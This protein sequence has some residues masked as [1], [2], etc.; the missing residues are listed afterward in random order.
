[1]RCF[2]DKELVLKIN[3]I[4]VAHHVGEISK[5]HAWA[6]LEGLESRCKKEIE[7][8]CGRRSY[9]T[10]WRQLGMVRKAKMALF[11]R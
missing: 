8:D 2:S 10:N 1:M 5:A 4:T 7:W 9:L 6:Q 3:L 11:N